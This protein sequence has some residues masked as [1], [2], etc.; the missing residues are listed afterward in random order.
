MKTIILLLLI[1]ISGGASGKSINS[2]LKGGAE[3]RDFEGVSSSSVSSLFAQLDSAI[4]RIPEYDAAHQRR[5]D[6]LKAE[7][8]RAHGN[9]A[10]AMRLN[11]QLIEAYYK[12]SYDSACRYLDRGLQL[13]RAAGTQSQMTAMQLRKAR[14]Y[15]KAGAYLEAVKLVEAVSEETLGDSLR[16]LYYE[17]C[18][19]V[20][21][22][23]GHYSQDS[24]INADY[25]QRASHYRQQL[26]REQLLDTASLAYFFL[27]ET[28]ARNQGRYDEALSW[29]NEQMSRVDPASPQFSEVAFFRS[30]IYRNM[31]DHEQEKYWLLRSAIGD[32]RNSIKDQASLWTLADL[33][34]REG[35]VEWSYRLIR[36][37]QD[38]LRLYNTPLRNLQSV[39]IL[40][41]IDHNYQ[42]M[43]DK[44][45]R[46]L[47]WSLILV[48]ILALLLAV[49]V[50]YVFLQ[51]KRL[52]AARQSLHQANQHLTELN[53]QLTA[54]NQQLR[55]AVTEL[56][57]S[58]G[59]LTDSNR[60]KEVYIGRFLALC[61]AY[62]KKMDAFRSTVLRK[63]KSGQ[64]ADYLSAQR[65]RQ[66][67]DKEVDELMDDFDNAFL[68]IF[69][70]F[71]S[72][73]NA[74]LTPEGRITPPADHRLTTELRIFALI[75]LG[76]A[77]SS[78]IAE[79]LHYS[80]HTIYNYRSTVKNA[81]CGPRDE[82]EE[83][84]RKIGSPEAP[85]A[86][87][88]S[89]SAPEGTTID[90]S[91]DKTNVA[92]S[93]AEGG[94]EG[95]A[96][97]ASGVFLFLFLLLLFLPLPLHAQDTN[98]FQRIAKRIMDAYDVGEE[99]QHA[100]DSAN[101]YGGAYLGASSN[102]R[103]MPS[104]YITYL[105]DKLLITSQLS[106]D[107]SELTTGKDVSTTFTTGADRLTSTDILTRHE[108]HDFSTRLD[109]QPR[110]GH[111]FSL[112]ILE[113]FDHSR[114]SENTITNGHEADG[115]QQSS[116]Y[117]E[118]RRSNRDLKLGGL[119]QY[120][121]DLERAGRLTAR[122]NLKYNYK[123]TTVS[124][125]TWATHT[126][127]SLRQQRQTLHNF[128]P[129]AMLRF[130]TPE[131][132]GLKFGIEEKFT[133]EDMHIDDTETAFNFDT[134]SSLT[135][136]SAAYAHGPLALDATLRY[137]H[138]VNDIDDHQVAT[139]RRTYN[140]WMLSARATLRPS[141]AHK[142]V[143][144]FD[145]TVQRPTYT[146]LYPFVHI[147]SSIGVMVVGNTA[148]DPSKTTQLKAAYTHSA[149][150]FT[151][152]HS[153][154]YR[155]I[156]DDISQVS[157]FDE[158]SQR[159][160][161]TWV[162]DARYA[163]LRY[164]AEGELRSGP[165]TATMG[166]HMQYLHYKGESRDSDHA[167]SYSFK[168][169]PQVQLPRQWTLATTLLYTGRETHRYYYQQP[170]FYWS[171]RAVKELGPWALYAFVQDILQP[172][173]KQMLTNTSQNTLTLTSPN[174]R[175]LIVG[176]SYTF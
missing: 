161:K 153:L 84:V 121:C 157:S 123:P 46:Q 126:E 158:A 120:I 11:D 110:Q 68:D 32:V 116:L 175:C 119:L 47:R 156:G 22:E 129:Y 104:G 35:D 72:D 19:D 87:Q 118:Q 48:G 67:K 61:S 140:D 138:F 70:T 115:T 125:D 95:G 69:P 100:P 88:A 169:R 152:T 105:K 159:S 51:M 73:F 3:V 7:A 146:Q 127:A 174:T 43:T 99:L 91:A 167:W 24:A 45:N 13:A 34:A 165:L 107:F 124:S 12:Y 172:D 109:Y 149:T 141:A 122:L 134:R 98:E 29:N 26:Q 27:Q 6:A 77:D 128:D 55:Q 97:G 148:L 164:A 131:W 114:I 93:G 173:H 163:T 82:F 111:I 162:N 145:R 10:E 78:R 94:A 74:L 112:G 5:I 50:V 142:L 9:A 57:E 168:L 102:G 170:T 39:S 176:C 66:M 60:I 92:P 44:Q 56:N 79:F 130:Q 90:F 21:G 59:L 53:Q 15:A 132:H 143:L 155:R 81:A 144:S 71:V 18:R 30:W 160:V 137:E 136:L 33:L 2:P 38:G 75:R 52:A 89:P 37:S 40:S 4:S 42:L 76:I 64:L 14:L 80:V 150:H 85:D 23:A 25:S 113:S 154:A 8:G 65:M 63:E 135:S 54:L 20:Y 117:E 151:H 171:L 1:F 101:L 36:T 103:A 106:A 28:N 108:K 49:A 31:G 96:L 41:M 147:G 58:N 139:D 133:I 83:Q 16:R 17:V 86:P 62:M 166:F